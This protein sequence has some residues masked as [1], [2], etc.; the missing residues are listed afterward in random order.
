MLCTYCD[1]SSK[2]NTLFVICYVHILRRSIFS[3]S[4]RSS[5]HFCIHWDFHIKYNVIAINKIADNATVE[6]TVYPTHRDDKSWH[7]NS[8][9][10]KCWHSLYE[11]VT[12]HVDLCIHGISCQHSVCVKMASTL[13]VGWY[14][15]S[16]FCELILCQ[17]FLWV[18]I[19]SAL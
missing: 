7:C 2:F 13:F 16:T 1:K 8:R 18:D 5:V 15:V 17:H 11:R 3:M 19:T 12:P 10:G 4:A 14:N 6:L 9:S